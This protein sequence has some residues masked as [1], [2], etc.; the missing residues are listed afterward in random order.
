[1][2]LLLQLLLFLLERFGEHTILIFDV[3]LILLIIH[4]FISLKRVAKLIR[5]ISMMNDPIIPGSV[6]SSPYSLRLAMD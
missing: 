3:G 6:S 4:Y 5:F 1:M 2:G